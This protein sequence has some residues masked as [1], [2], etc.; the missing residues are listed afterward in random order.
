MCKQETLPHAS[1]PTSPG[2]SY[3]GDSYAEVGVYVLILKVYSLI[4]SPVP[5]LHDSKEESGSRSRDAHCS[6]SIHANF[7]ATSVTF[8]G[9]TVSCQIAKTEEIMYCTCSGLKSW[10]YTRRGCRYKGQILQLLCISPTPQWGS[11]VFNLT[12]E[13]LQ[14]RF[15]IIGWVELAKGKG[16][17]NIVQLIICPSIAKVHVPQKGIFGY[18]C[19]NQYFHFMWSG[20]EYLLWRSQIKCWG[21]GCSGGIQLLLSTD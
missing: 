2:Y 5:P 10:M 1:L 8:Q 9:T 20:L 19:P 11:P 7:T 13:R 6:A 3:P 18:C 17:L 15:I 21:E 16:D 12:H 14:T 4:E